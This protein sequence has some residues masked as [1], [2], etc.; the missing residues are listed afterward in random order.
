MS[1]IAA[2]RITASQFGPKWLRIPGC[3][4]TERLAH[5]TE[6]MRLALDR[7]VSPA[8]LPNSKKQNTPNAER[9]CEARDAKRSMG[10]CSPQG[11]QKVRYKK[12]VDTAT[13][14]RRDGI[15]QALDG[16]VSHAR[17]SESNTRNTPSAENK[18]GVRPGSPAGVSITFFEKTYWCY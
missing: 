8:G 12:K 17:V 13:F 10:R 14:R 3:I 16:P 2:A 11:F 15:R 18:R 4:M 7:P 1:R 5:L 9:N 6:T